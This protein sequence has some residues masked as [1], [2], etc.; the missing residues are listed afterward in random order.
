MA[1]N[2][3]YHDP[4]DGSVTNGQGLRVLLKDGSRVILRLSGTGTK[5]AT[6]R[7]YLE[8]YV[9]P[10]GDLMQDPQNA[11]ADLIAEIDSLAEI[12]QRTGMTKP[13]VIT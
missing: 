6:L 4:V 13:T 9:G 1:D 7:I 5:G 2:F 8:R 10:T 12:S 11:L 3:S